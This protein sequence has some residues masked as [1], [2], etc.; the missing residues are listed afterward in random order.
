MLLKGIDKKVK[1]PNKVH[2][3]IITLIK[4]G[5]LPNNGEVF[6]SLTSRKKSVLKP[7]LENYYK[8]VS[9]S[10]IS[11]VLS[12]IQFDSIDLCK[13]SSLNIN[14]IDYNNKSNIPTLK[15]IENLFKYFFKNRLDLDKH[16]K[17]LKLKICPFCTIKDFTSFKGKYKEAYDHYFPIAKFPYWGADM[18]NLAPMC[19]D[20]NTYVKGSRVTIFDS[21]KN[22]QEILF[23]YQ[24]LTEFEVK[25]K[26]KNYSIYDIEIIPTA[27]QYKKQFDNYIN[28]FDLK[29]RFESEFHASADST[30]FNYLQK[31]YD[32]SKFNDLPSFKSIVQN[33]INEANKRKFDESSKFLEKSYYEYVYSNPSRFYNAIVN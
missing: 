5:R 19:T 2:N 17:K 1:R 12:V 6:F 32:D 29:N 24:D 18:R 16:Y 30:W 20:C 14:Y 7:L 13:N 31:D 22:R 10:D 8:S 23:P 28:F 27:L 4:L 26:N 3:D 9:I 15:I 33:Y 11:I 25:V 21:N